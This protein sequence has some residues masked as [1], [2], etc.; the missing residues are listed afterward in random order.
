MKKYF[1]KAF[2]NQQ[3]ASD[4]CIEIENGNIVSISNEVPELLTEQKDGILIPGATDIHCHGGGGYYFSNPDISNI[5]KALT[6]HQNTGTSR[7][8]ASLVTEPISDLKNQILRLKS[9]VHS[10]E[11]LGIHLEGP[12]LAESRCGAHDPTLLRDPLISELKELIDISENTI[13]MVTIAPERN[14][15]IEAIK[16][17]TDNSIVAAIGHSDA[18]QSQTKDAIN[19]GAKVFTHFYNGAPKFENW[20]DLTPAS[21]ASEG[22]KDERVFIEFI[23]DGVHL[24]D[25]I[26]NN[27][28]RIA[29]NRLLVITDA[30]AA[31][32]GED[33]EYLI[34]KLPVQVK[35]GI[36]TL[37]SNGSL[38]GST[39]TTAKSILRLLNIYKFDLNTVLNYSNYYPS[40]VLGIEPLE[41]KVGAQL[42]DFRILTSNYQ[43]IINI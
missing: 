24:N 2:L 19:A 29:T 12:Y 3:I 9:L 41:L 26:I 6:A 20:S 32:A 4:I 43:E 5:R 14:G 11:I 27:I 37:K 18:T 7:L 13:K 17:L 31:A 38:A 36:A 35:E 30:M 28:N 21:I 10:G 16:Y 34:G 25:E 42:K 33:G 1:K 15:A 22:L 8:I 39:L 40:S 23:N